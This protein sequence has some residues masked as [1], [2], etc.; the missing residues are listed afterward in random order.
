MQRHYYSSKTPEDKLMISLQ[1]RFKV[2]EAALT[3]DGKRVFVQWY[4]SDQHLCTATAEPYRETT[5]Q[6]GFLLKDQ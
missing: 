2:Q 5:A 3:Q 6:L 4:V 1:C